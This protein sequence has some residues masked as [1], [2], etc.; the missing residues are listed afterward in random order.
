MKTKNLDP[1]KIVKL[2]PKLNLSIANLSRLKSTEQSSHFYTL[3]KNSIKKNYQVNSQEIKQYKNTLRNSIIIKNKKPSEQIYDLTCTFKLNT[4]IV[5]NCLKIIK[6]NDV[7]KNLV[8]KRLQ[9][10]LN[11][12]QL[13]QNLKNEKEKIQA[14]ILV[15]NQIY[16]KTNRDINQNEN[17][18]KKQIGEWELRLKKKNTCIKKCH[19]KFFDIQCCIKEETNYFFLYKRIYGNY[20]LDSFLIENENL[21]R[22]RDKLKNDIKKNYEYLSLLNNKIN[23]SVIDSKI[24]NKIKF[25]NFINIEN[26]KNKIEENNIKAIK[27]IL[28]KITYRNYK[29]MFWNCSQADKSSN[30]NNL[31]M[32]LCIMNGDNNISAILPQSKTNDDTNDTFFV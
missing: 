2:P 11:K 30:N 29:M 1:K 4:Q 28:A 24:V 13:L 10:I 22:I 6:M 3:P 25:E 23:N 8:E 32:T 12:F 5:S 19:K 7:Q 15:N 26:E 14:K 16:Q 9:I 17:Q 31:N 27:D 20:S 18:Y 21:Q